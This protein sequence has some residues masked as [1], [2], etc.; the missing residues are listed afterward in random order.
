[1]SRR[2]AARLLERFPLTTLAWRNLTRTRVRTALATLGILVGVVAIASLGITGIAFQESQVDNFDRIGS[3][4]LI[5]PGEDAESQRLDA[6]DRRLVQSNTDYQTYTFKQTNAN[7]THLREE[8]S[9]PL[10]SVNRPREQTTVA[11]GSIPVS[12]RDGVAVGSDLADE[13]GVGVGDAVRVDGE[14]RRVVAVFAENDDQRVFS[15]DGA[16]VVPSERHPDDQYAG[17]YLETE[18]FEAAFAERDRLDRA[19]NY[20]EEQYAV[21]DFEDN[22]RQ[23]LQ[24]FAQI[25]VFLVG[26]GAVSLFVASVSIVN[27]ML[28]STIER[29][30][31]I[32]VF[33]AVGYQRLAVLRLLLTE[34]LL[35]GV[36]GAVLGVGLSVAVGAV[37]NQALL[38]DPLAFS[39]RSLRYLAFGFVFGI[40]ASLLSGLYPAWRAASDP[41]VESLRG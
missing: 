10:K 34:A 18:S 29:R 21:R 38:G 2:V 23:I 15:T 13:L 28:M 41:P 16:I 9:A 37:V 6:D 7:V 40:V 39:D 22:V 11:E 3:S 19:L 14:T 20:Q 24:L 8:T 27:V 1:V 26:I 31:E 33:R 36:V 25:N 12:W 32:G 4:V 30:G 5:E 35:M 17:L